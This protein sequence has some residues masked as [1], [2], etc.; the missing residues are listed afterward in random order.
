MEKVDYAFLDSLERNIGLDTDILELGSRIIGVQGNLSVRKIFGEKAVPGLYTGVDY[1]EGPGVDMVA[2]VQDIPL[3]SGSANS[4]VAFN[5]FE[6]VEKFW[7]VFD[8]MK[9]IV[10]ATGVIVCATPFNYDIHGCPYD[11][12]RF[13]PS[14]YEAQFNNFKYLIIA[15]IGSDVRPKMVYAVASNN[16]KI[17]TGFDSFK[18]DFTKG[19]RQL[20]PA[21]K[22]PIFRLRSIIC[23]SFFRDSIKHF[24]DINVRLI[25]R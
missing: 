17:A 24:G 8:E 7:L 21:Y 2:N 16:N 4:I 23:G 14:F 9:R 13:T 6:H 15:T 11:Y 18:A 10:S 12:Y 20:V 5:L 19:F 22:L 3:P 1:I 25:Q